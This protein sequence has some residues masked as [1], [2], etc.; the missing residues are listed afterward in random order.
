MSAAFLH[1]DKVAAV[2]ADTA[3]S[4][5]ATASMPLS[6][7]IDPQPRLR[8]RLPSNSV[9]IQVDFGASTTLGCV[10]L[11]STNLTSTATVTVTQSNASD[12]S[13]PTYAPGSASANTSS[14]ANGNVVLLH[15]TAAAGRY[16]R[17]LVADAALTYIDIG[18]LVA[19]P[20]W[21]LSYSWAYG[22]AEGRQML[23]RRDRNGF[24]GAEFPVPAVVNPRAT[25]FSLERL[26]ST[27]ATGEWRTMLATLGAV[28]DALWIPDTAASQA[29]INKRSIWGAIAQ[30]GESAM[31]G[32]ANLLQYQRSFTMVERV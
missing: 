19:G 20:L 17:L 13:A 28:G 3:T 25:Q 9:T 18:R 11:I 32:R 27:E 12:M 21:T 7:L 26:T 14:Q 10:A 2:G 24:T 6:N 29:E 5:T 4:T 8:A 31:L 23:D 1:D 15:A 22:I 30:P 16:L